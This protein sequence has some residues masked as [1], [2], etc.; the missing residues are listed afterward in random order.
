MLILTHLKHILWQFVCFICKISTFRTY[1]DKYLLKLTMHQI[2]DI[3][4]IS[5]SY[6]TVVGFGLGLSCFGKEPYFVTLAL[7]APL[8]L[9]NKN[10]SKVYGVYIM[11]WLLFILTAQIAPAVNNCLGFPN[12]HIKSHTSF[13]DQL[14]KIRRRICGK[15]IVDNEVVFSYSKNNKFLNLCILT[16]LLPDLIC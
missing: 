5:W 8:Q 14:T 6:K 10:T 2:W 4:K 7:L 11:S 15:F 1:F 12:Q 13:I 3:V 16:W 9:E